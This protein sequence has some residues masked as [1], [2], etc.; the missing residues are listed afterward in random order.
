MD[1]ADR[2]TILEHPTEPH[3]SGL[4]ARNLLQV[5][6]EEI[7][8]D[9]AQPRQAFEKDGID[10]MAKS[11]AARGVLQPIR[12]RRDAHRDCW[13]LVSGETRWRAARQAGLATIPALPVDGDPSETDLLADQVTENVIRNSL[14]PMELA[15]S[16]DRLKRLK[17][18]TSKQL[19][20]ELGISGGSITR[21]EALLSLPVD[22]QALIDS[23]EVSADAGYQLS[24]LPDESSQRMLAQEI[25]A[26]RVSRDGAAEAVQKVIG[27]RKGSGTASRL[28][29]RLAGGVNLT[30]S[31]DTPLTWDSLL[32]S[33]EQVRK[34]ADDLKKSG[35]DVAELAKFVAGQARLEPTASV[36]AKA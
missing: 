31:A 24:R 30:L 25:V 2:L 7:F 35:K 13:L 8:P 4:P 27:K 17:A 36:S 32:R 29:L 26:G 11:I 28:P 15:R 6:I 34:A 9:L 20:D 12:I 23:G 19:A 22:L 1:H 21:S 3:K 16:L 10:R 33:L 14:R 5:P 18:C